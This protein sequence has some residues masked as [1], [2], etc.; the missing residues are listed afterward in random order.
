MTYKLAAAAGTILLAAASP[1]LATPIIGPIATAQAEVY[2]GFTGDTGALRVRN[3]DGTKW[4]E[5]DGTGKFTPSGTALQVGH[6]ETYASAWLTKFGEENAQ[7]LVTLPSMALTNTSKNP[8]TV[9]LQTDFSSSLGSYAS[10]NDPHHQTASFLSTITGFLGGDYHYCSLAPGDNEMDVTATTETVSGR[11]T[12]YI[13]AADSSEGFWDYTIAP[14]STVMTG[15]YGL[16][17]TVSVTWVDPPPSVPEPMTAALIG[18]GLLG[19]LA[20][21]RRA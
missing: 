21:R 2:F 11:T 13:N 8:I 4:T 14:K 10:V 15:E 17:S 3:Q 18:T 6:L 1:A 20:S 9:H 12:C 5:H 7:S 16:W 19:L